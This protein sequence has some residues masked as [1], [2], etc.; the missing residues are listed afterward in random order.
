MW[1]QDDTV[2]V[3]GAIQHE[4]LFATTD[5][6]ADRTSPR[7]DWA[8]IDHLS[9][10][11]IDL[12][13]RWE[14]YGDSSRIGFRG[15]SATMRLENMSS[16]ML[17]YEP[18]FRGHGVAHMDASADFSWGKV[19][20]G[21]VY[22]QF[23]S[24]YILRLYEERN[25]GVDNALRGAKIE[26]TPYR[27]INLTALGGKQRRYWSC[28]DDGAWGYN[29]GQDAAIG[30]DVELS[31]H[32]WSPRMEE[33]GANLTL[34]A[35]WVSKYQ[36]DPETPDYTVADGQLYQRVYPN[37]VAATDVRAQYQQ[38]GW[39]AAVEYA[40]K[41]GD[42]SV[43]NN[44][45]Y[46]PGQALMASL[47]YSRSGMSVIAQVKHSENM[48]F[49]S[50]RTLRGSAGYLN[51]MP[52]FTTQQT[53]RLATLY[54]YNTQYGNEQ[55]IL[56]EWAFQGELRYTFKRK[57]KMGGK[58]GTSFRLGAS[59][60]RGLGEDGGWSMN[61]AKDGEYYT[62]AYLEMQ[63]KISSSWSL[64]AMLMYQSYNLYIVEGH[65]SWD[66]VDGQVGERE[67]IRSGIGILEAKYKV[68]DDIQMRA[69]AQYAYTRQDD[70]Q[71]ID[72]LYELS[73]YND[74]MIT[75]TWLHNLGTGNPN[76][77]LHKQHYYTVGATYLHGA[78]RVMLAYTKSPAGTTCT[79]GVCR[80]IPQ[81]E[82]VSLT[83]NYSF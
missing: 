28:Y 77:E 34:G 13:V 61:T 54:Q 65:R 36:A 42:P 57:T 45:S 1:A 68:T 9:N 81:Q 11:Y 30:A 29:Y 80:K 24:G 73:L 82:G 76:S 14:H 78:H 12:G 7:P 59:H 27:G 17:G 32:E 63:K 5:I 69:E 46:D 58:Y 6:S 55:N 18:G 75:A 26:A 52:A 43:E 25:I 70:G 21:D 83:Y 60:I 3:T 20:L 67:L 47:S 31:I 8:K 74:W 51:H 2:Y 39:D 56:G 79:G 16:P 19:T 66:I 4:S 40:Y 22:G 64:S 33:A 49:R 44:F 41:A 53:Y 71:W 15:L 50:D 38:D 72:L 48:A 10:S 23:G 37:W 35:S 62:D